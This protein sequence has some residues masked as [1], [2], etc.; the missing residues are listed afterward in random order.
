MF[1]PAD[2]VTRALTRTIVP[3][4]IAVSDST[5]G[6]GVGRP[7]VGDPGEHAVTRSTRT[8]G[9]VLMLLPLG[10]ATAEHFL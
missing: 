7:M 4:R 1:S 3:S 9:E 2:E 5:D 10:L 6:T 8:S